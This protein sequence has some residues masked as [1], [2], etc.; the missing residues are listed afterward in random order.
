MNNTYD[1][2][3]LERG[4]R[5]HL[6][7]LW[8]CSGKKFINQTHQVNNKRVKCCSII[9]AALHVCLA[10]FVVELASSNQAVIV[11]GVG[12]AYELPGLTNRLML[13]SL[14]TVM[15][16]IRVDASAPIQLQEVSVSQG[17][18]VPTGHESQFH[19]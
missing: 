17:F 4:N 12:T 18:S 1:L 10:S 2:S 3:Q 13:A 7:Y 14:D 5:S 6:S 11:Q 16:Q 19:A 9:V 15:L 8:T